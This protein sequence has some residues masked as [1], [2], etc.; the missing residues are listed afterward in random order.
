MHAS[1]H[2]CGFLSAIGF[3]LMATLA[4]A[5]GLRSIDIP[6]DADG[7]AIHG[8]ICRACRTARSQET[9]CR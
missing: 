8:A 2:V 7:P 5:A 6:A 1:N 4:Q 9:I 3:C